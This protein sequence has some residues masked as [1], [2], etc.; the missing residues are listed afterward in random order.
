MKMCTYFGE[1]LKVQKEL[2]EE[3]DYQKLTEEQQDS[4]FKELM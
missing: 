4:L 3:A 1:K 2:K